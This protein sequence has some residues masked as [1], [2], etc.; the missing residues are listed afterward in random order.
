[1]FPSNYTSK[2]THKTCVATTFIQHFY[3]K[4]LVG[5]CL[6]HQN[7]KDFCL[8][9]VPS[10]GF[11]FAG[12]YFSTIYLLKRLDRAEQNLSQGVSSCDLIFRNIPTLITKN[13]NFRVLPL[14][15]NV[16]Y[17]AESV[18][19]KQFQRKAFACHPWIRLRF[20]IHLS[21][22]PILPNWSDGLCR[23]GGGIY[24]LSAMLQLSTLLTKGKVLIF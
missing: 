11:S 7:Y 15:R 6:G 24:V 14:A 2:L 4:Q 8:C 1:M 13:Q 16:M 3:R 21:A 22:Q 5:L 9:A 17:G 10:I 19:T 12:I 18:Q 23:G 20:A